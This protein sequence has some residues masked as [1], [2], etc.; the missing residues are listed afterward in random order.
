MIKAMDTIT[1]DGVA[2]IGGSMRRSD[3]TGP[4]LPGRSATATSSGTDVKEWSA[5]PVCGLRCGIPAASIEGNE[6]PNTPCHR[7]SYTQELPP[8]LPPSPGAVPSHCA[9]R[10]GA[11]T[12]DWI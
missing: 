10:L 2:S 5:A 3:I 7:P 1:V 12:L 11:H 8:R 6:L 9:I 4:L